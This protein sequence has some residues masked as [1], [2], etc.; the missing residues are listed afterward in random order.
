MPDHDAR[1]DARERPV[2]ELM[3]DL[4]D[5]TTSLVRKEV[6]LA[7]L[8]LT[9][10]GKQA[11]VGHGMFGAAALFGL[12]AFATLTTCLIRALDTVVAGWLAALIGT[13]L[14]A[15]IAGLLALRGVRSSRRPRRFPSGRSTRQR[16]TSN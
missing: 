4:T 3:R 5:H 13:V 14:S 11:G 6:E 7:K 12:G 16:R 9:E 1:S 8:E 2:A 15:A 10:K